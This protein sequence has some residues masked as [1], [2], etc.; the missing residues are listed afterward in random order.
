MKLLFTPEALSSYNDLKSGAPREAE[1]V[2]DI[3]KDIL[4]HPDTG[5][6]NP[7]PLTGALSGLWCRD[8]GV[9]RQI[10][11]SFSAEEVKVFAIGRSIIGNNAAPSAEVQQTQY[12]EDDYRSVLAQMEANCGRKMAYWWSLLVV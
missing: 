9:F 7:V 12:S 1:L 6:G 11:Y 5:K 10:V 3:I 4:T 8:Y 2:R